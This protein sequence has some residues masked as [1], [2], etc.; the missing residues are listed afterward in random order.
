MMETRSQRYAKAAIKKIEAVLGQNEEKAYGALALRFPV[1]VLQGGLSQATGFL[2]AK[3]KAHHLRFLNDL[4]GILGHDDGKK[5]H[6]KIIASNL[7][8]YQ[9]LTRNTLDAAAWMKRYA[10][11][12]LKAEPGDNHE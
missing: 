1:M 8:D 7:A 4:A 6:E 12:T 2:L 11:G 3:G 9:Q 10:Q 5:L